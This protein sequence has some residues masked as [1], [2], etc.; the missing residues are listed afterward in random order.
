MNDSQ[1]V[2]VGI[3]ISKDTLSVDA[4]DLFKGDVP[5]TPKGRAGLVAR[6][7]KA[8]RGA[9]LHLCF[10][11]TGPYG[12]PLFEACCKAGI[13]ASL[14]N[15][16]KV[17]HFAKA[18]SRSAKTDPIDASVIRHFA[19]TRKPAPSHAPGANERRIRQLVLARDALT[20]NVV[21][22]SGTLDSLT[23][24]GA[25]KHAEKAIRMSKG[26][27]RLLDRQ[28]A[29][30]VKGDERLEGLTGTLAGIDGVGA[31][32][33]AKVVALVPEL[34]TLG[35]RGSAA[36]AG[37]APFKRE[38]GEYKGKAFIHGGRASLRQALFMP[39]MVAI[40][41]NTVLK[42]AYEKLVKAGKPHKVALTA[43]IRKLFAH[44]D[45]LAAKWLAEHSAVTGVPAQA[46]SAT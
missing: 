34:G 14:L 37:V 39:A 6:L 29:E 2:Y 5:N 25:K 33:A 24:A 38:S 36:L 22:L 19:Q 4:G 44:M 45:S 12:A 43:V 20:K 15:P 28:I 26:E 21:Q 35:R 7:R 18:M 1:V 8:A 30:T 10:E 40:R 46:L 31:L 16:A 23:D 11:S 13:R 42:A 32:T 41:C 27:I 3:D 9:V 17:R